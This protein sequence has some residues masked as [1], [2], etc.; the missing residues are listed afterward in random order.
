MT[1]G[2]A[3]GSRWGFW[4][5]YRLV[6]RTRHDAPQPLTPSAEYDDR[7]QTN[8]QTD[9]YAHHNTPHSP[10]G[11]GGRSNKRDAFKH[12]ALSLKY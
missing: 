1:R 6:L 9:R 3:P 10:V 8:T 11:G 7:G 4:P 5:T 2:S 12:A